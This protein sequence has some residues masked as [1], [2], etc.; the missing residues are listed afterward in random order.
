MTR[1]IWSLAG[2]VMALAGVIAALG[3]AAFV[4]GFAVT[5]IDELGW[6]PVATGGALILLGALAGGAVTKIVSDRRRVVITHHTCPPTGLT[7]PPR[8]SEEVRAQRARDTSPL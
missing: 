7:M 6:S 8:W 5:V 4:S 2:T 1:R 3:I